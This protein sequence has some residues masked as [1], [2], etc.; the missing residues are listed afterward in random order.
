MTHSPATI[1][2]VDDD[3]NQRK[4]LARLLLAKG[5]LSTCVASGEEALAS[6]TQ[7]APDLI[8]LDVMMPGLDG[9]QVAGL[10]KS[11][12]ATANI[13]IIMLTAL[14]DR[15]ARVA[16]FEA[17]VEEFLTKPIDTTELWLRVRNLLRLKELSDFQKNH[18][19]LLEQELQLRA[20]ELQRF[21]SAMD[22]TANAIVLVNRSSMRFVDVNSTACTLVGYTR[23]ELLETG[24]AAFAGTTVEKLG[25]VYDAIIAGQGANVLTETQIQRKDGTPVQVEI[26]QH[27]E[28][29][30]E[31][32]I[33]VFMLRDISVRK[34]AQE[35]V[36]R[37]NAELED[38]VRQRTEQLQGANKQLEAFSYSVSH[39]LRSPLS[40]I[41]GFSNLLTKEL[42]DSVSSERGR[43][44]LSRIRAGVSQMGELID[45]LLSLAHVARTKMRRES[46]DLSAM[47]QTIVDGYQE[48]EPERRVLLDIQPGLEAQG[49]PRLLQ[50]ALDNL[51]SNAWKFSGKQPHT[52]ISFRSEI[53]PDGT[54]VYVVQDN[55]AGFDMA[56]A[57]KLFGAFQRLH[58]PSE[59]SGT[60][61]GLATVHRIVT[62]HG[63]R[64]WAE[65]A[66]GQGARFYFT[67]GEPAEVS[68]DAGFTLTVAPAPAIAESAS[69]TVSP[70]TDASP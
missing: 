6:I 36:L 42:G 49:D 48:I 21:R 60:G 5:Y 4:L 33:M 15:S 13:P 64:I 68:D 39:D 26:H 53:Q 40:A 19:A 45:S 27:A 37:L 38:R 28:R 20:A 11:N 58:S 56:Y 8:L 54:P 43:H 3:P 17:G 67:I 66:R 59:F 41:D 61:I 22:A 2:V 55:G 23:E 14:F 32:W 9:Y 70:Q 16:G 47:A 7:Q 1:L 30:G 69:V 46:V 35:E 34:Q 18:G 63:G 57:D 62:R 52:Q 31:D 29:V 24:P 50:Q 12:A 10:I 51:L 65:S 44:Y 25:L